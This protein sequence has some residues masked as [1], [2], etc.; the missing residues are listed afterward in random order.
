MSAPAASQL[1]EPPD[2]ATPLAAAASLQRQRKWSEALAAYRAILDVAPDHF[3]TLFRLGTLL[4]Q[5]GKVDDALPLFA[6]A[7][8]VASNS[9]SAQA[10]LGLMFGILGRRAEAIAC[11][12]RAIA[13]QP[14]HAAAHR[15]LANALFALERFEPA[16]THYRRALAIGPDGVEARNRL[17]EALQALR[18]PGEAVEHF[19][20]AL[21]IAPGRADIHFN[22]AN[23]L[24]ALERRE[25]AVAHYEA[26]VALRPDLARAHSNLGIV[27]QELGHHEGAAARFR[28]AVAIAPGVA[29][30]H[31]NLGNALRALGRADEAIT[32][33]E[34]ALAIA[35]DHAAAHNNLGNALAGLD[36]TD[37]AI[38][39]Y[40]A[41]LAI[42]PALAETHNNLGTLI[43]ARHGPA[44]AVA[45]YRR[46]LAIK[47]DLAEAYGNLANA[48][49]ALNR[50]HEAIGH[51][52]RALAIRPDLAEA[53]N[54]LGISL[55]VLGR[56]DEAGRAFERAVKLAP[57][58]ADFHLPLAHTKP[59]K[60]GDERLPAMQVLARDMAALTEQDRIA[61][62]FALGKAFED[63]GEHERSFRHLLDGNAL[64]RRR[65]A[66]DEP[67]ILAMFERIR[68]TFTQELI[69]RHRGAGDPR[70]APVFVVG[71]PRS[72]TTLVE[73]ILASHSR[74]FGAGEREDLSNALPGLKGP[75]GLA[76]PEVV[77]AMTDADLCRFGS[78]YL[79]GITAAAP[80]ADRIVDKMPSNFGLLGLIHLALPNA[81]IIHARRDP[82]DTCVSCFA[83]LFVGAGQSHTYDLGELG[84]YYAAYA[85]LMEH[86]RQVL[87]AGVM[88]DVHYEDVVDDLEGQGR[89][90]I[91][92]CGLEWEEACL[93][94]HRTQRPVQTASSVQ[95]RQPIYRG[96]VGRW[97]RYGELLRPLLDALD[98]G[99]VG[100]NPAIAAPSSV[101]NAAQL[102]GQ[103]AFSGT[104]S[105]R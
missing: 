48:L 63:L 7:S 27:L 74:V 43:T 57:W 61:L 86:W 72:G 45:H 82:V 34:R 62:H 14:D 32:H 46:A 84:R 67:A 81:R 36:R 2:V 70:A 91:S 75:D 51:Y 103:S 38:A 19:E 37:E 29:D 90:I 18:R 93:D 96:S 55:Q 35:P 42:D 59:F 54:G 4:V 80:T 21:A 13:V 52:E 24:Q 5:Q 44:D 104:C 76:F 49:Q 87:P 99:L 28:Q 31:T 10:S 94:F 39:H 101:G 15:H 100:R 3:A 22:L 60:P 69:E 6:R 95:V 40:R 8:R 98:A 64:K 56:L 47:P 79:D 97:R 11:Y 58:K 26:A 85:A 30:V 89:R 68:E 105:D 20:R 17:G 33:Y 65:V 73:Q 53:H 25:D 88:L 77:A 41:A 66:Y 71:M 16:I 9:A 78:R 12:Q 102:S 23:A 1:P 50:P 92:H 83:I